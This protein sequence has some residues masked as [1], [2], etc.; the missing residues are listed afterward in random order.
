MVESTDKGLPLLK[1]TVFK[2]DD[3]INPK[4]KGN[5]I[6]NKKGKKKKRK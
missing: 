3:P 5:K 1:P 2:D 4:Y 6:V